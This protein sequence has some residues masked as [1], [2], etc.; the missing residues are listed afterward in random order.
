MANGVDG[1]S[2]NRVLLPVEPVFRKDIGPAQIHH[3]RYTG[4][5]ASEMLSNTIYVKALIVG[6]FRRQVR[7]ENYTKYKV[8]LI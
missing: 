2:G 6:T 5:T 8:Q 3:P 1:R 4:I 7:N